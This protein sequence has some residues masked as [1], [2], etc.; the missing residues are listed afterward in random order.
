M[1]ANICRNEDGRIITTAQDVMTFLIE[2]GDDFEEKDLPSV[3]NAHP[4]TKEAQALV[5]HVHS[6]K[7]KPGDPLYD[8]VQEVRS[9]LDEM[10]CRLAASLV[11]EH[12]VGPNENGVATVDE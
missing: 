5:E 2:L 1:A 7:Y 6:G 4:H 3:V 9:Q 8:E 10:T 12:Y 11:Y